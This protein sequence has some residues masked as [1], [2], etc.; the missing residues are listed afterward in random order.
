M[1]TET[2][3]CGRRVTLAETTLRVGAQTVGC[4]ACCFTGRANVRVVHELT[5]NPPTNNNTPTTEG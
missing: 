4:L 5:S 1:D 3:R 2:C